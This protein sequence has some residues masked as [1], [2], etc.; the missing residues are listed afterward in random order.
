MVEQWKE[1]TPEDFIF[2]LKMPKRITHELK[3]VGVEKELEHFQKIAMILGKKLGAVMVQ[4][5]PFLKCNETTLGTLERFLASTDQKIRYAIEFRNKSWFTHETY[6][7]LRSKKICLVWSVNEYLEVLPKE[8]TTSMIYLRF[9]GEFGKFKKLDRIQ[10]DR[11]ELLKEWWK[12]LDSVLSKIEHAYVLVSNHFAGFAPETINQ[13]REFA[14]L[15]TVNWERAMQSGT[16][17]L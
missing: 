7:L 13:F 15:E 16:L 17:E 1:K 10:I 12:N 5:P 2:T 9:M 3:L 4:L 8:V 6:S 11:S 14:G